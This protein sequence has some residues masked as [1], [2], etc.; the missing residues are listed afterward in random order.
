MQSSEAAGRSL[1]HASALCTSTDWL[2][3][4]PSCALRFA[5]AGSAQA[6]LAASSR[7]L[8]KVARRVCIHPKIMHI[9]ILSYGCCPDSVLLTICS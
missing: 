4:T 5:V 6:G 2:L 3:S 7:V 9:P 1:Q 8:A